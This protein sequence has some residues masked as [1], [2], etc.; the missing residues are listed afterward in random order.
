[1]KKAILILI[2]FTGK[3]QAQT[4]KKDS[5]TFVDRH[6][7][8]KFLLEPREDAQACMF[9]A[10]WQ[11]LYSAPS[12]GK[13]FRTCGLQ[14][15]IGLNLARFFSNKFI[16]GVC[17]DVKGVKGFT[18][19]YFSQDLRNDFNNDFISSYTDVAD[20]GRA[21]LVSRAIN[22]IGMSGNYLG[23][24]GIMFSPFP[25]KFGGIMLV[26]KKGYRSYVIHGTYGNKY[27]Y[28]GEQDNATIDLSGNYSAEITFKPLVFSKETRFNV[29]V[30]SLYYERLNLKDAT[31]ADMRFDKMVSDEF[32]KKYGV[33]DRFGIKL[34][35]ALY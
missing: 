13:A 21:Y 8:M 31:F 4:E 27:V 9:M 15:I 28:D 35:F 26:L 22:G 20:S 6:K 19:Q 29:L 10:S 24:Y 14:P 1:M 3:L 18:R 23:E 5:S 17:L 33:T 2:L 30:V 25:K 11:Y 12:W 16:L 7:Y 34:G 32:L